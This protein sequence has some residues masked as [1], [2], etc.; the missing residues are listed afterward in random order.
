[1]SL[2]PSDPAAGQVEEAA[3]SVC[4]PEHCYHAFDALYC[5]LTGSDPIPT[6]FADEKYPLFVTWNTRSSRRHPRL[7]GCI[8][9]FEAQPLSEGLAEYALI[10][11]FRDHRFRKIEEKEL[12]SLECKIS[13]LTDFEDASSYL[14]WTIGVHGISI[15]F[16]H[17]SLIPS[18]TPST[19]PG[20]PF[21]STPSLPRFT[22]KQSF[23]A[24]YLPE[25]MP[26]QGWDKIEAIDS[27][28]H[29][30]GWTGRI[31][32]DLRR[33]IRLRRYQSSKCTVG[34]D[35]Y[36]EWRQRNGGDI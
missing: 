16:P 27:A 20:S 33:S 25:V 13:L 35:D 22:S 2:L 18:S 9:T 19:E 7:R 1:M 8:G 26:E 11:A 10:S 28:I 12:S 21:S 23:S 15:S 32:E 24:T 31:T 34:W 6:K 17:P 3:S 14:D 29:K 5:A 30:A 36:V 4:T